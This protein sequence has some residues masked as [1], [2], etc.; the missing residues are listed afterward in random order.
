M[1]E[2]ADCDDVR[3]GAGVDHRDGIV[4]D[5]HV[6]VVALVAGIQDHCSDV[7]IDES[8]VAPCEEVADDLD[9]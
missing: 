1:T 3:A 2:I 9:A 7:A 6:D 4:D 8:L 5:A